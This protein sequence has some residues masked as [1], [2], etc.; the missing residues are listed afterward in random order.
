MC[1][2][3]TVTLVDQSKGEIC[4]TLWNAQAE[5]FDPGNDSPVVVVK[6][7]KVSDYNG[8]S[9]ASWAST[10]VQVCGPLINFNISQ[11]L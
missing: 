7:A 4:L 2:K 6:G 1:K 9:L 5:N 10:I 8:V 11:L 3:R